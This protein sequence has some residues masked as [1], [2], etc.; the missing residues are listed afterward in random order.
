[1]TTAKR[2]SGLMGSADDSKSTIPT[3]TQ[4]TKPVNR[5]AKSAPRKA[6][7]RVQLNTQQPEELKAA[8]SKAAS[9]L[10]YTTG[11]KVTTTEVVER[12]LREFLLSGA[13]PG[14][15]TDPLTGQDQ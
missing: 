10:S 1:M 8:V 12:A 9:Y 2:F 11:E 13:F 4:E 14:E 15:V 7:L 5:E 3:P 6:A